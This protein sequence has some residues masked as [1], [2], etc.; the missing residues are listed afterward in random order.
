MAA[1]RAMLAPRIKAGGILGG[2]GLSVRSVSADPPAI[3]LALTFLAEYSYCCDQLGCHLGAP[4]LAWWR[5]FRKRVERKG[6]ELPRRSIKLFFAVFVE[7]GADYA[8]FGRSTGLMKSWEEA[9]D[10]SEARTEE[11]RAQ[12]RHEKRWRRSFRLP[13]FPSG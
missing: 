9:W 1:L 13:P 12:D 4:T 6:F 8:Y 5:R 10:E 7:P 11:Q 2:Y 3:K